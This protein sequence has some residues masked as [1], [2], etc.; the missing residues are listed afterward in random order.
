[1]AD[2]EFLYIGKSVLLG[3]SS[4][5]GRDWIDKHVDH[6]NETGGKTVIPVSH[7]DEVKRAALAHDL[8]IGIIEPA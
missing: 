3:A 5:R 8:T 4:K 2:L 6:R 1:M 7:I